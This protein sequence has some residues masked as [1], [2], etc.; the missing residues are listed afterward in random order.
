MSP[1]WCLYKTKVLDNNAGAPG[2][3]VFETWVSTTDDCA[4][5]VGCANFS[6]GTLH[7]FTRTSPGCRDEKHTTQVMGED[8]PGSRTPRDPGHPAEGCALRNRPVR[9]RLLLRGI[10]SNAKLILAWH[11]GHRSAHDARLSCGETAH[12]TLFADRTARM[13]FRACISHQLP[14]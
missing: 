11:L 4:K 9:R 14:S 5:V 3:A 1:M 10:E 7:S 12:A 8:V 6:C 2:L 13:G